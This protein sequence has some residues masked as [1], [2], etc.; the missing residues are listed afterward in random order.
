MP[1]S[2]TDWKNCRYGGP[3]GGDGH[4]VP[5][6]KMTRMVRGTITIVICTDCKAR[7]IEQQKGQRTGDGR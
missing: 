3:P 7:K 5:A 4:R 6:A 1:A 2:I